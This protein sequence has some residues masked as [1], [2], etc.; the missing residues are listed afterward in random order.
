M[1]RL[2]AFADEANSS[3]EGQIEALKRNSIDS[4]KLIIQLILSLQKYNLA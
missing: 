3:L 4:L 1:I 2:A